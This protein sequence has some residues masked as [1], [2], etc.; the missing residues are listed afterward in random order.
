MSSIPKKRKH[1]DGSSL[2]SLIATLQPRL[3]IKDFQQE[4]LEA[5]VVTPLQR[6]MHVDAPTPSIFSVPTP[7]STADEPFSSFL[8]PLL[9]MLLQ[10]SELELHFPSLAPSSNPSI[11]S[12]EVVTPYVTPPSTFIFPPQ[13]PIAG[14]SCHDG[15]SSISLK[16]SEGTAHSSLVIQPSIDRIALPSYT[17]DLQNS[18]YA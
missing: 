15:F 16:R 17:S 6:K 8:Q 7:L 4:G 5:E 3:L 11:A 14:F 2:H 13:V 1:S 10:P 18:D 12:S 9:T